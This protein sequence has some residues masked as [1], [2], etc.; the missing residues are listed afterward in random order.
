MDFIRVS[1]DKWTFE[2]RSTGKKFFPFGSNFI[3]DYRDEPDP[4][5]FG[6]ENLHILVED[7]WK[8]EIIKKAFYASKAANLN[9]MKVFMAA[10]FV[11]DNNQTP[12]S[13]KFREMTPSLF[14]RLDY[15]FEIAEQTGIYIVLTLSEWCMG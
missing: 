6:R 3:F 4:N 15:L 13:F 9:I 5:G 2:E 12:G 8:P 7:N 14:E 11:I 10:P 1:K